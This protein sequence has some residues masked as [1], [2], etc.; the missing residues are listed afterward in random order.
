MLLEHDIP[1]F[2]DYEK[3]PEFMHTVRY[4]LM[5]ED[6]QLIDDLIIEHGINS[7]TETGPI[8]IYR[9][10]RSVLKYFLI[11]ILIGILLFGLFMAG[12]RVFTGTWW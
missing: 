3:Y 4:W 5:D 12:N 10:D 11:Y 9:K 8:N 6:R 7:R 1:F 2:S